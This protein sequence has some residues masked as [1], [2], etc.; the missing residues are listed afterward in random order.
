MSN[1]IQ[2]KAPIIRDNNII[3]Q[4][5][6]TYTPYTQSYENND[7]IRIAIQSQD[8]NVLPSESY[9]FIE[10]EAKRS[11]T[12]VSTQKVKFN[13]FY[14]AHLFSEMRYELNGVEIDRCKTPGITSALKTMIACKSS[15]LSLYYL[16]RLNEEVDILQTTY[17]LI[18]PL[19]FIFGFCDDYNK[20]ILNS[21]HE[22]IIIRNRI[23]SGLCSS[24][25]DS[26]V[27]KFNVT[28]IHWK[29]PHIKLSDEG[30]L[31]TL[32]SIERDDSIPMAYRSWDLYDLP[33]VPQARRNIWKVK[34]TTQL[35]KPRFVV[36]AFQTITDPCKNVSEFSHCNISDVK[37]YLNDERYPYDNLNTSFSQSRYQEL[38]HTF[39]KIHQSYYNDGNPNAA[40]VNFHDFKNGSTIFP[41]DCSRSDERHKNGTIDVLIEIE[42]NRNIPENTKAYCLIIHDNLVRYSPLT[43]FVRREF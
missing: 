35:T 43:N 6:H 1:I 27:F 7:E 31:L 36:V 20:I 9:L 15:D 32:K 30:R 38:Y 21:K 34:T 3:S 17:S 2:I 8:L 24:E 39:L 23:D 29:I 5:Y 13:P 25:S 41:F 42:S 22:L 26:E 40:G 12:T 16:Y 33:V 11:G 10:F 4:Q 37:L 14:L 28:K 19:R 18:L